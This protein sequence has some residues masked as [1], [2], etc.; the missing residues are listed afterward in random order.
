MI[1]PAT[2]V[3]VHEGYAWVPRVADPEWRTANGRT[4]R[5][6]E[7]RPLRVCGRPA[8]AEL[9]RSEKMGAGNWWAYCEQHLYGRWI[10]AG[11]IMQWVLRPIGDE[12]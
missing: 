4:C 1:R 9:K 5:W 2:P 12:S 3:S 6:M 8:V 11:Q 7:G 10:E